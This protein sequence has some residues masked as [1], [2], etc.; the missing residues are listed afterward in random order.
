MEA[1]FTLVLSLGGSV[2]G[3]HGIGWL[4]RGQ[5]RHQ[6]APAAVGAHETIK[7]AL[8]PKGLFNPRKK[9]A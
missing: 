8:D 2:T 6:W 3:E 1:L 9:T 5:L 7:G 4:K